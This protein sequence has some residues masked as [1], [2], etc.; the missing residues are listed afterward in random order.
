PPAAVLNAA[1]S[2]AKLLGA[3]RGANALSRFDRDVLDKPYVDT[4]VV[5]MGINDIGWAGA[6]LLS[7]GDPPATAERLIAGYRQLVERA[8]LHRIKVIGATILP[9]EDAFKGAF[10][11][12]AD[13]YG[14]EKEKT[15]QA[16][17]KW[18]REA[19]A[20]DA[21]FDLDALVR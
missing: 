3:R 21:V 6:R 4:V 1:I 19:G 8:H 15:R 16:V 10:D 14:P 9:F 13:Y 18:I 5:L 7:P 2:G 17:N 12:M 11:A 20:F